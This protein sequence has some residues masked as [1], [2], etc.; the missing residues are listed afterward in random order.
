MKEDDL[1]HNEAGLLFKFVGQKIHSRN[2][3]SEVPMDAATLDIAVDLRNYM[4][5]NP[6]RLG[7]S[8]PCEADH[9]KLT[10]L[11]NIHH[12]ED[13]KVGSGMG[14]CIS[15]NAWIDD[16]GSIERNHNNKRTHSLQ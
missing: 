13:K 8:T 11:L 14:S 2:I 1:P 7:A 3:V 10:T 4:D 5:H 15:H 9:A 6:A 16:N 12:L